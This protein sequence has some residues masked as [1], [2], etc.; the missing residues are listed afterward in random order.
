MNREVE[1]LL[2]NFCNFLFTP[3]KSNYLTEKE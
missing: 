1:I 2:R 3:G